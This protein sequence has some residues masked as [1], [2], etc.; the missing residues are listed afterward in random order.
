M[1]AELGKLGRYDGLRVGWAHPGM[2]SGPDSEMQRKGRGEPCICQRELIQS[3][4]EELA[5]GAGRNELCKRGLRQL[6]AARL[7]CPRAS[8]EGRGREPQQHSLSL[9]GHR[10]LAAAVTMLDRFMST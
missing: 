8:E 4:R 5:S 10:D 2:R 3:Q 9:H 7:L 1:W 6:F